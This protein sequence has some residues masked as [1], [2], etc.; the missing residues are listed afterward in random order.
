MALPV[1]IIT[2][3]LMLTFVPKSNAKSARPLSQAA[4]VPQDSRVLQVIQECPEAAAEWPDPD[5]QDLQA[6][7][8]LQAWMVTPDLQ[9]IPVPQGK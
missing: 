3:V 9:D 8:A 7:Q 4:Q 5:H 1:M 2:A 6:R